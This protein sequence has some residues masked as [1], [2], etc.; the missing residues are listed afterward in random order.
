MHLKLASTSGI[1]IDGAFSVSHY[2][3]KVIVI[4]EAIALSVH[5]PGT[6]QSAI[7]ACEAG[8]GDK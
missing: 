8:E 6:N 1:V 4:I 3:T 5:L 7:F 2:H